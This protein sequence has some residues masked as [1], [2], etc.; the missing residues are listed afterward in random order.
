VFPFAEHSRY[1]LGLLVPSLMQK[2]MYF[3]LVRQIN[4]VLAFLHT[5]DV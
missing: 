3:L 1:K 5:F 2:T 4:A